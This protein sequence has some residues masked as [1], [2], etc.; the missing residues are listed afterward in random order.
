M[1]NLPETDQPNLKQFIVFCKLNENL[2]F[3]LLSYLYDQVEV[4]NDRVVVLKTQEK[5]PQYVLLFKT[6]SDYHLKYNFK[7]RV[8]S[9]PFSFRCLPVHGKSAHQ[10]YY[11]T[12]ALEAIIAKESGSTDNNKEFIVDWSKY[13]QMIIYKDREN[14]VVTPV[15]KVGVV[16][17]APEWVDDDDASPAD[18]EEPTE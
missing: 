17:L 11:T 4:H 1:E 6:A 3:G 10:V 8:A 9:K 2:K 12:S 16:N 18:S 5:E 15:E 14:L 7:I 13:A